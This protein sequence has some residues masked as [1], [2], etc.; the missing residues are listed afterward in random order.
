VDN[1]G[2]GFVDFPRDP[3]CTSTNDD[4]EGPANAAV[5]LHSRTVQITALRH[6][7]TASSQSD[8][9]LVKGQ[10][11]TADGFEECS[12]AAPVKVQ[13]RVAGQWVTRKS[14]VTNENGVFK[15][16]VRDVKGRYRAQAT[17]RQLQD[18]DGSDQLQEC[19]KA[20]DSARHRH[21]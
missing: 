5:E 10:V 14:D 9:L 21:G 3:S 4:T 7:K 16:L 2:D 8:A 15:V 11:V 18:P 17:K 19:S 13:L 1:D 20:K 6:V 12:Q